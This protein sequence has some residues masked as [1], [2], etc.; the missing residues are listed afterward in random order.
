MYVLL[1][2]FF[3][4]GGGEDF[5][6]F[7]MYLLYVWMLGK[8]LKIISFNVKT[9]QQSLLVLYFGGK[10]CIFTGLEIRPSFHHLPPLEIF[11]NISNSSQNNKFRARGRFEDHYKFEDTA[12][13]MIPTPN[14]PFCHPYFQPL[15]P[16]TPNN[17]LSTPVYA[18]LSL[19]KFVLTYFSH[20]SSKLLARRLIPNSQHL[21]QVF[22]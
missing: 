1:L 15:F 4:G 13:I 18:M 20:L 17:Y 19:K 12:R 16:I 6:F 8:H 10:N 21:F 5:V 9:H 22:Q 11:R 14:S 7:G 2:V 3:W